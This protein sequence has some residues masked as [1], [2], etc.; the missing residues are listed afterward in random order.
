MN[1]KLLVRWFAIVAIVVAASFILESALFTVEPG[2]VGALIRNSEVSRVVEASG[3][4]WKAPDTQVAL[5]DSRTQVADVD[6]RVDK[7]GPAA[8]SAGATYTVAWKLADAKAFYH[9]TENNNPAADVQGK[10]ADAA[11][12]A[13]RKLLAKPGEPRVFAVPT[14]SVTAAFEAAIKPVAKKIGIDIQAV[15]LASLKLSASD[16]QA[17]AD[18]MLASRAKTR[19]EKTSAHQSDIEQQIRNERAHA[20]DILSGA[21]REA[22]R[23]RGENEAK[24]AG[25]YARAAKPAP[26]FFDFYQTLMS[27]QTA[28]EKKTKLFVVSSDSPWFK[29]LGQAPGKKQGTRD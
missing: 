21:R 27:E 17:L 2:Q 20:A 9:A 18:R 11:D 5:L 22:A 28:L 23:I 7:S 15:S 3:V 10:L 16:Q 29:L 1:N 19:E 14:A 12:P 24:I 6:F 4:H 26:A 13:L 25:I 8:D